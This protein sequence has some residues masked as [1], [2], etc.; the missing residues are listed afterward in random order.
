M[1]NFLLIAA[2]AVTLSGCSLIPHKV[3]YFQKKVKAV[4]ELSDS[5]KEHQKE[6]ADYVAK[7]TL[8]VEHAAVATHADPDLTAKATDARI[9]AGSLSDSIGKPVS[10]TTQTATNFARTLDRDSAKLDKAIDS[11][12]EKVEPLVGKKIEGTGFIQIGYF[13][14][15]GIIL[16]VGFLILSGLKIYGMF[17][18]VV[19]LGMNVAGRVAS[20][21]LH[22]GFG[23]LIKGGEKFKAYLDK[24]PAPSLT[25]DQILDLFQRAHLESQDESVQNLVQSLTL[26]PVA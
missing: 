26:K 15:I 3:E 12:R 25:K 14:Q 4:P 19:G 6:A 2:L 5:A 18:P 7:E 1:K 10:P 17:N 13:T 22:T 23:Q 20:N 16:G 8:E 21:V 24:N 9:V 11:Y